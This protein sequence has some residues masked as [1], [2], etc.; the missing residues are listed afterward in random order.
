[1]KEW[2]GS[3]ENLELNNSPALDRAPKRV[4][5]KKVAIISSISIIL[6]AIIMCVGIS[7]YVGLSLTKPEKKA[8]DISPSDYEI[9]IRTLS[10]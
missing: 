5:I 7:I 2:G 9:D 3:Y 8:I 10:F 4:N 1:M 6:L